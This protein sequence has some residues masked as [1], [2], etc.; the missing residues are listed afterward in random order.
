MDSTFVVLT[1]QTLVNA[2]S[3]FTVRKSEET[4]KKEVFLNCCS[5]NQNFIV[6][7]RYHPCVSNEFCFGWIDMEES[8]C[9]CTI[10]LALY[11][12]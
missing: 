1:S 12:L 9:V 3:A 6:E 5:R 11:L 7:S 2:Q 8:V 10:M 4:K